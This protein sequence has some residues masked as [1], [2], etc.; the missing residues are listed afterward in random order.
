M[1]RAPQVNDNRPPRK[2]RKKGDLIG[3]SKDD[4][5]RTVCLKLNQIL[6]PNLNPKFLV[7]LK[8]A[9]V[10]YS[11]LT[12][13]ATILSNMVIEYCLD[14]KTPIPDMSQVFFQRCMAAVRDASMPSK[15]VDPAIRATIEARWS[16]SGC[17]YTDIDGLS[18]F[19]API[20][21]EL[22]TNAKNHLIE[23]FYS[24]QEHVLSLQC[25][26]D[27]VQTIQ[28]EINAFV[29]TGN[30]SITLEH[31][32]QCDRAG[33]KLDH[34]WLKSPSNLSNIFRY[35]RYMG[36]VEDAHAQANEAY[37]DL[38][39][40]S[41][42]NY[43]KSRRFNYL[44]IRG[45]SRHHI[46]IQAGGMYCLLRKS[47]LCESLSPNKFAE[48]QVELFGVAFDFG[49]LE[50][51]KARSNYTVTTDGVRASVQLFIRG[52]THS[53]PGSKRKVKLGDVDHG[54]FGMDQVE[55]EGSLS[56]VGNDPGRHTL[57]TLV[58]GCGRY[59]SYG[60][61]EHYHKCG[62]KRAT[63]IRNKWTNRLSD[64]LKASLDASKAQSFKI[65]SL[66]SI[67]DAWRERVAI[68]ADLWAIYGGE[69]YSNLKFTTYVQKQKAYSNLCKR[70][71]NT[72]G[73]STVIAFGAA[74]FKVSCKGD[75]TGPLKE[76][77]TELSKHLRV[78]Y[79][80][81]FR[82]SVCCHTCGCRMK[83]PLREGGTKGTV[84]CIFHCQQCKR[85]RNRDRNAARNIREALVCHLE[86]VSVR[87][88][89]L[90]STTKTADAPCDPWRA[91]VMRA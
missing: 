90:R 73:S 7:E 54:L 19:N 49:K 29:Y 26:K 68:E 18:G 37:H 3:R 86:G 87:S 83:N 57:L 12:H 45:Y 9:V 42:P 82:S 60:K 58:D 2:K 52:G 48:H 39:G 78:V 84:F 79:T 30:R 31:R 62:F 88:N 22:H 14:T 61:H 5:I 8:K 43:K 56:V 17:D 51:T 33:D 25:N 1:K 50:T 67:A 16:I 21:R 6:R 66:V 11:H 32:A 64:Q 63:F 35:Y 15:I 27:E 13:E 81:E 20:A 40:N 34:K 10:V 24:R 80:P 46:P 70:I 23:N 36:L 75:V 69:N 55:K 41:P 85:F 28:K 71:I 89:F 53:N 47:G 38:T 59:I 65:S 72:Y 74:K 76:M 44:P 4:P 77:A 91:S